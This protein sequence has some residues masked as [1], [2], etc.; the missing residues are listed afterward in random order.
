MYLDEDQD[1]TRAIIKQQAREAGSERFAIEEARDRLR[2]IHQNAQRLLRP[3]IHVIIPFAEKLTFPC[4][5]RRAR[6]DFSKLLNLI[7]VIAFLHQYQRDI[8]EQGERRF[9]EATSADYALAYEL[10]CTTFA[11]TLDALD[12]RDRR[13]LEVIL[14]NVKEQAGADAMKSVQFDRADVS[15]WTRKHRNHLVATLNRLEEADYLTRVAGG[16]GKRILY[17]LNEANVM[18]D[19]RTGFEGLT[20]PEEV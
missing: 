3:D 14:D 4:K 8:H 10:A 12:R 2:R 16:M 5:D 1:Q 11:E 19:A 18:E 13:L 17:E 9:I 15:R 20:Q 6:R 7:R